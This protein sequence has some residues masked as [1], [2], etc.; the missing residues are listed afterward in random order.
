MN[1]TPPLQQVY[2]HIFYGTDIDRY[3]ENYRKGTEPDF[4][5][6]GFHHAEADGFEVEFSKDASGKCYRLVSRLMHK[7]FSVDVMHAFHNRKKIRNAD[8]IWTMTEREAFAIAL[9]FATGI[10]KRK[11]IVTSAVWLFNTWDSLP[12]FRQR[13]YTYLLRYVSIVFV[14]SEKYLPIIRQKFSGV[15]SELLYFGINT[16]VYTITP[17]DSAS[18]EQPIKIFS[19]GNDPTR[20]WD[21]ILKAFGNDPRFDITILCNWI[22]P[23]TEARYGNLKVIRKMVIR[24]FIDCYKSADFVVVAMKENI[25]SGIT[26]ALEAAALGRPI[27]SSRTGGIPTYFDETEVVYIQPEDADA[28]RNAV[29]DNISESRTQ[30]AANAQKKFLS[31]DYTTRAVAARYG[32]A[33]NE[34]SA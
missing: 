14:H 24:D 26:V 31:R 5:P 13:L 9:L 10:V 18:I 15:R 8:V 16:G 6:Y 1:S 33:T 23:D 22:E 32:K 30:F 25:F 2:A 21:T 27:I 17:P 28:L 11:P 29:L 3:K 19:A 20:D 7:L 34:I 4:T 12:S